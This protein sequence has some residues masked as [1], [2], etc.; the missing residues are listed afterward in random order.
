M[1]RRMLVDITYG[2]GS[3]IEKPIE[4]EAET[5]E[6]IAAM[7]N[8]DENALLDFMLTGDNHG[9]KSFV[10]Q[11]LMFR[12]EGLLVAQIKEPDF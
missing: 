5:A 3:R 7:I 1:L 8:R 6:E 9:Q 4:Y 10:F 2:G 12:K 11:G